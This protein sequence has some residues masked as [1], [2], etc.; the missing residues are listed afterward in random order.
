MP[1]CPLESVDELADSE[2]CEQ[3]GDQEDRPDHARRRDQA[4]G[5]LRRR[6]DRADCRV[7]QGSYRQRHD[8]CLVLESTDKPLL[9]Q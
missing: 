5:D 9:R 7:A 4:E 8:L 3:R 2:Q 6:W 1:P